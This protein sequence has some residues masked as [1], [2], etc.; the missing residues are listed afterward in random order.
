MEGQCKD[1]CQVP[2]LEGTINP[3]NARLCKRNEVAVLQKGIWSLCEN[4]YQQ[5]GV[6]AKRVKINLGHKS[7]SIFCTD[8]TEGKLS[9]SFSIGRTAA[10]ILCPILGTMFPGRRVLIWEEVKSRSRRLSGGLKMQLLRKVWDFFF[11]L[12]CKRKMRGWRTT[13]I[14]FVRSWG[15]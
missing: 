9:L 15:N 13:F 12:F 7:K 8:D 6:I 4:Q 14:K 5:Y 11:Y 2:C 1:R 3:V 10:E